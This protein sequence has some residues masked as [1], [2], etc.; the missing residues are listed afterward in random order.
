MRTMLLAMRRSRLLRWPLVAMLALACPVLASRANAQALS[1]I[2]GTVVDQSGAVV[3]GVQITATNDGTGVSSRAA[4]TSAGTYALTD[5]NPGRYTVRF[6]KAGFQPTV[7]NGVNVEVSR[8]IT[9]DAALLTGEIKEAIQV[10]APAIAMETNQPETGWTVEKQVLEGLPIEFGGAVGDRGRQIDG[11]L[12]LVPG[13]EGDSFSHRINGGLDF[14]NEIVFNGIPVSQAETQGFQSNINPPYDMV[15]E[16]RVLGSVFSAQYGLAQGVASYRFASGAN[17]FHGN[18]FEILHNTALNAVGHTPNEPGKADKDV[19]HNYGFTVSGPVLIPGV[20]DGKD[21]TFF[22][23]S[24]E[25]YRL[26]EAVGGRMTVPTEAMKGGDFSAFPQQIFVPAGG[27]IPGCTPGA[28]PGKQFPGNVIPSNCISQ[29]SQSVLP[30]LPNPTFPGFENNVASQINDRATRQTNWGFSLDHHLTQNQA[31]HF[32]FWRDS[33]NQPFCCDN[34]ALYLN[35]LTGLKLEPRVG[36]GIFGSYSNTFSDHF[37][38]TAGFGYM[39]EMNNEL[40][41]FLGYNFPGVAESQ[42]FPTVVYSGN[43]GPGDLGAGNGG[44]PFSFNN[45]LGLS[46]ASNFLYLR[47]RHTLNFGFDVRRA[48]QEDQECQNCGARISFNS[49]TTADPNNLNDTGS[50]FASFL[51]GEVNQVFRQFAIPVNLSNLYVAPYIQDDFKISSNLTINVGLRWDIMRPFTEKGNNIVYADLTRPDPV[52]VSTQTGQPILGGFTKFGDCDGCAGINRADIKWGELSPRLG[53]VY[54]IGDKSVLLSGVAVNHLDGGVYEFGTNKVAVNYAGLLTGTFNAPSFGDQYIP[55]YGQWDGNPV[56]RP[57][58]TPFGPALGHGHSV[59]VLGRDVGKQPIN[60]AWN[61]GIQR[62]LPWNMLFTATYVGNEGRHL[63]SQLYHPNGLDPKFLSLCADPNDCVLGHDWNSPE[64]QAVLQ[65]QGF[66]K[67]ADGNYAPYCGF[68]DEVGG[69][70][71][72]ALTP[73]PQY[74]D[75][76]PNFETRGKAV[77]NALQVSNQKRFTNGLSFLVGYTLS[78]AMSNADSGFSSFQPYAIN[79]FD[80]GPEYVVS[81]ND[82]RHYVQI[83]AVYELPFGRNSSGALKQ[84]INGWRVS[85]ALFYQSGGPL[86]VGANGSPL[87]NGNRANF[88]PSVPLNMDWSRSKHAAGDLMFQAPLAGDTTPFD[89]F[90]IAAFSSPGE[91][92]LGNSPRNIDGLRGPWN[93]TENFA[94]GKSI[95]I[96]S[97]TTE[98]RIEFFNIFNRVGYCGVNTNVDDRDHFGLSNANRIRDESG[99]VVGVHFD[100]CQ[101]YRPRRGQAYFKISF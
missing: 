11:L 71:R 98:I 63:P 16:V 73:F 59:S 4:T 67:C 78:K 41:L 95:H 31:L 2:H 23:T 19:R 87:N 3:E 12:T 55:G 77:Y 92:K 86:G 38:M 27:L 32:S 96:G 93:Q 97:T 85:T 89:V 14:Q 30:L 99:Q 56:P 45:K 53:V 70:L 36:K 94:L 26:N 68:G 15:E 62:E 101:N 40:N 50:A 51:L 43:F 88:D 46:F 48:S 76:F 25:W 17:L 72:Q 7:H 75:V 80:T 54:R 52:A 8:N 74:L 29:T 1:G 64:A 42:S 69:D 83:S 22:H 47:G 9:L 10:T 39:R 57:A 35:E 28:A 18:A 6:E 20:Y 90:N 81:N 49:R 13:V 66:G 91:W 100:E 79:S 21:K 58:A 34:N 44:E 84:V 37:I 5:L 82:H 33:W 61:V 65:Q 24:F 60:V